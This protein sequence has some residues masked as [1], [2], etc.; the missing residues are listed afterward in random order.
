MVKGFRLRAATNVSLMEWV[1]RSLNRFCTSSTTTRGT[2]VSKVLSKATL[3]ASKD[4]LPNAEHDQG[5]DD[6]EPGVHP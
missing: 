3:Q 2:E 6:P 5:S 4:E 1:W